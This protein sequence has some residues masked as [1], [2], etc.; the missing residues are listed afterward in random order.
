LQAV[1]DETPFRLATPERSARLRGERVRLMAARRNPDGSLALVTSDGLTLPWIGGEDR[2]RELGHEFEAPGL[3]PNATAGFSLAP[4][5]AP[6]ETAASR[7]NNPNRSASDAVAQIP[8]LSQALGQAPPQTSAAD[9]NAEAELAKDPFKEAKLRERVPE[10]LAKAEKEK[11]EKLRGG[12]EKKSFEVPAAPQAGTGGGGGSGRAQRIPGGD[13]RTSFS[14]QKGADPASLAGVGEAI[15]K[16]T[17]SN[18]EA[19]EAQADAKEEMAAHETSLLEQQ[20]REQEQRVQ[21]LRGRIAAAR[22]TI[23]DKEAE[24]ANE[25][26]KLAVAEQDPHHFWAGKSTGAKIL[27]VIGAIAGGFTSGLK[28]GP[29]QFIEH[30]K[31]VMA[32]DMALH[33]E[34]LAARQKNN[35]V[36]AGELDRLR[37]KMDPDLAEKELEARQ[38]ALVGAKMRRFALN[39]AN[40]ATRAAM[41]AEADKFEADAK[42][43]WAGLSQE[44]GDRI[45]EQYQNI[46]DQFVG[47]GGPAAKE[48]DVH[49][50]AAD[51]EKAGL[52]DAEGRLGEL[53]DLIQAIPEGGEIPTFDTRNILSR[54]TRNVL[55]KVGGQGTG[56][57]ALDSPAERQAAAKLNAW[58]AAARNQISGAS[59]TEGEKAD[60]ARSVDGVTTRE[61]A[62]AIQEALQRKIL[63]RKAAIRAGIKPE[64]VQTY[65]ERK[66][67]Y[68]LPGRPGSLRSE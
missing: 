20:T 36:R 56:A 37:E 8:G 30:L 42:T 68:D 67:G 32:E 39:T 31:G 46:P 58:Q 21:A 2:L 9:R 13:T 65:E 57:A 64:A 40:P 11:A 1:A 16:S 50:Y 19:L 15:E 38:L 34:K 41:I 51:L 29:N 3:D 59:L 26:Q 61:G 47:G 27:A 18:R 14:I 48:S 43:R 33:R 54:A 55:D 66:K 10:V 35:N 23:D 45:V 7:A 52:G 28:G 22:T 6:G 60:F 5:L 44:L 17:A 12:A 25:R 53:N 62:Q 24:L 4:P 49:Q 63:R